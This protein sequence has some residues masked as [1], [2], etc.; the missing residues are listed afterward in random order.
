MFRPALIT[1]FLVSA[2]PAC[3]TAGPDDDAG[4]SPTC[5]AGAEKTCTCDDGPSSVATC[6]SA[7]SYGACACGVPAA[8]QACL[9]EGGTEEECNDDDNWI[10][11]GVCGQEPNA[12]DDPEAGT[13]GA[14]C[15][16]DTD[17]QYGVCVGSPLVT[18]ELF[19]MCTKQCSC[20]ENSECSADPKFNGMGAT[21]LRFGEAIYPDEPMVAYCQHTC[22]SV[23]DCAA[24]SDQYNACVII[25]G[26]TK[27]CAVE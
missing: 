25:V 16:E 5:T 17:C 8:V 15:A 1:L 22:L 26:A 10:D 3:D 7:G 21:C 6:T 20:G 19:K 13:H 24:L 9:D 11:E 2:S 14:E 18:G 27:V 12:V 23:A 4:P